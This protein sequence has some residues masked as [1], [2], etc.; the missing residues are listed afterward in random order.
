MAELRQSNKC[1]GVMTNE[2][3]NLPVVFGANP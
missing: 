3:F 1:G 2:I